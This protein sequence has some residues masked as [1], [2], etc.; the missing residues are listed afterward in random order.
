MDSSDPGGP[1][2][3]QDVFRDVAG[4]FATGV[5]VLTTGTPEGPTGSTASAVASLSMEP[6]MM[7]VCLNRASATHDRIRESGHYG[8][9]ILAKG[10]EDIAYR[11]SRRGPDKFQGVPWTPAAGGVPLITGSLATIACRVVDTAEGGTHT[12]F[13]GEVL[14]AAATDAEP[15]TYYRG[16]FGRFEFDADDTAYQGLRGLVLRRDTA[17]GQPL[18]LAA[19]ASELGVKPAFVTAAAARLLEQGLLAAGDRD[20]P[21]VAP[22]GAATVT[23][24]FAAQAALESG[25]VDMHLPHAGEPQLDAIRAATAALLG[26]TAHRDAEPAPRVEAI[27]GVHRAVMQLSPSRRLSG[28][29]EEFSTSAL[30]AALLPAAAQ[31]TMVDA[32]GLLAL[33]RAAGARDLTGARDAIHRH[34]ATV[35]AFASAEI[36]ARGGTV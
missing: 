21:V 1:G 32:D 29:F 8:V 7:L 2:V 31:E 18:D 12:I 17:P 23:A 13:I 24:F 35:S 11:F 36:A 9:N 27:R 34:L 30:W 16:S 22:L 19:A 6:P 25:V 33:G 10:Q 4:R 20:A 15:L 14:H 3:D 28:A 26:V 5:T